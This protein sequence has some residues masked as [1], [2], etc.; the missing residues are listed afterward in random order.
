MF[1]RTEDTTATLVSL[2]SEVT[3]GLKTISTTLR[4]VANALRTIRD[5]RL[6]KEECD[7]FSEFASQNWSMSRKQ[8][9]R[10][11]AADGQIT[12]LMLPP[13]TPIEAAAQFNKI[14][15]DGLALDAAAAAT[16]D[17]GRI[18]LAR[19]KEEV[20]ARLKPKRKAKK[21]FKRRVF[22]TSF[23]VKVI[24]EPTRQ[25][26]VNYASALKEAHEQLKN[27]ELKVKRAA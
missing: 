11:I 15:D 2:K 12:R 24:L 26:E 13:D 20:D 22:K 10:I 3:N 9:D 19:A 8:V 16:D 21:T 17:D 1:K 18:I 4:S 25:R 7:T 27:G 23:G 6:Y 14:K 5:E